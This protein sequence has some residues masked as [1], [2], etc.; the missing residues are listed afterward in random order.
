MKPTLL[1]RKRC[2]YVRPWGFGRHLPRHRQF[3]GHFPLSWTFKWIRRP[4][5][6]WGLQRRLRWS[7]RRALEQGSALQLSGARRCWQS[8]LALSWRRKRRRWGY[9]W[10]KRNPRRKRRRSTLRRSGPLQ[11]HPFGR[12]RRRFRGVLD[13]RRL[14]RR[15]R[16]W[17][18]KMARLQWRRLRRRAP[19]VVGLGPRRRHRRKPAHLN[20]RFGPFRRFR[21]LKGLQ[22]LDQ[23][24]RQRRQRWLR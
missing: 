12:L 16:R 19:M 17:L 6:L 15:L 9:N 10:T 20:R 21:R 7:T 22:A 1:R 13:R 2:F 18:R 3:T 5:G 14:P 4:R 8:G 24:R 11:P 23:W